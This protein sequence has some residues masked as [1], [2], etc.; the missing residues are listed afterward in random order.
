[1]NAICDEC[2]LSFIYRS[3]QHI[4][5]SL[6]TSS[7]LLVCFCFQCMPCCSFSQNIFT[8][9]Y[10]EA[11]IESHWTACVN[12]SSASCVYRCSSDMSADMQSCWTSC[13][14]HCN[15]AFDFVTA[16]LLSLSAVLTASCTRLLSDNVH[17]LRIDITVCSVCCRCSETS[18]TRLITFYWAAQYNIQFISDVHPDIQRQLEPFQMCLV[19]PWF[20]TSHDTRSCYTHQRRSWY[21]SIVNFYKYDAMLEISTQNNPWLQLIKRKFDLFA[22]L[23]SRFNFLALGSLVN[24]LTEAM[25]DIIFVLSADCAR[26]GVNTAVSRMTSR[27]NWVNVSGL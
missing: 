2:W 19:V 16:L 27:T 5:H 7:S 25:R 12:S 6:Q 13:F 9:V 14:C 15:K 24:M 23:L 18:W 17:V 21:L 11:L 22:V 26:L 1:M 3:V 8:V 10:I 4:V 20:M